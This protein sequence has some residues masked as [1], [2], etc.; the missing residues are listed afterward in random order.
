MT[1]VQSVSPAK[2]VDSSPLTPETIRRLDTLRAIIGNGVSSALQEAQALADLDD[3]PDV[4][5]A[6]GIVAVAAERLNL[7]RGHVSKRLTIGFG[8]VLP[9]GVE[10]V[11]SFGVVDLEILYYAAREARA[12]RLSASG[13]LE[14]V[15][16]CNREQALTALGVPQDERRPLSGRYTRPTCESWQRALDRTR[17]LGFSPEQ[18][19]ERLSVMLVEASP[20]RVRGLLNATEAVS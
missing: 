14:R 13:A 17:T 7:S 19:V 10:D 18:T 15:R 20:E 16:G 9:L 1:A 4:Q 5:A 11:R 6:G 12:S 8:L 2:P 3:Y